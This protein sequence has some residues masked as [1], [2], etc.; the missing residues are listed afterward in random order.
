[1]F[2]KKK[3]IIFINLSPAREEVDEKEKNKPKK[4]KIKKQNKIFLSIIL[5]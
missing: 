2:C 5:Q 3:I 4:N 1:M